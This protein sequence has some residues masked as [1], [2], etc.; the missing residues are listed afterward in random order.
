MHWWCRA[1][2]PFTPNQR[3]AFWL[4][5]FIAIFADITRYGLEFKD[6]VRNV[7]LARGGGLN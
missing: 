2:R 4:F 5:Q 1:L 6:Y 3:R 7:T